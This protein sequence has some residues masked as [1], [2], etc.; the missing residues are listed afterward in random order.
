MGTM[1]R[2]NAITG[3]NRNPGLARINRNRIARQMVARLR[4]QN[5]GARNIGA[6]L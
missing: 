5:P 4:A 2:I 1:A 6:T 3:V